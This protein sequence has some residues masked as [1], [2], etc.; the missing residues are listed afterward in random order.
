MNDDI[1]YDLYKYAGSVSCAAVRIY[2]FIREVGRGELTADNAL[3]Q[4][5]EDYHQL[6]VLSNNIVNLADELKKEGK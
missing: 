1:V 2:N 4:L 6:K 3:H 5:V